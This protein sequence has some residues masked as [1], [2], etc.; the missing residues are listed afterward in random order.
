MYSLKDVYMLAATLKNT[1]V[2][3]MY[4]YIYVYMEIYK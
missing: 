3:D 4:I 1:C 2:Q